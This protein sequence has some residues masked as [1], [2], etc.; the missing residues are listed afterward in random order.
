MDTYQYGVYFK[1]G[2]T[3]VQLPVNPEEIPIKY[4]S[5]NTRYNVLSLGEIVVPRIPKL[6]TVEFDFLLVDDPSAI[7]ISDQ[8]GFREPKYYIDFFTRCQTSK[9]PIRFIVNRYLEDGGAIFDTNIKVI[10]EDFEA[11]EKGGETGDFY[12]SLTLTQYKDYA[13]EIVDIVLPTVPTGEA[14]AVSTP[15]RETPNNT[16]VVGDKV[17]VNGKFWYTS[18]GESP[19]GNGNNRTTTVTRIIQSPKSG[20]SY[21][22]LIGGNLGWVSMDQLKKV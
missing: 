1:K 9:D 8:S 20:Q 18:Y 19:F 11:K 6:K 16:I 10:V 22:V 17:T 7:L 21:P 4:P 14:K 5:D 3:I 13:S 2:S 12:C 15:Q